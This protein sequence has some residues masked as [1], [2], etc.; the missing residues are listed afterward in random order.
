MLF[1]ALLSLSAQAK[2]VSDFINEHPELARSPS[3][4][5]AIQQSA[6]GLAGLEAV[7]N[8][9]TEK[10]L[11]DDAQ[12]LLSENGYEHAQAGLRELATSVCGDGDLAD[13]YGLRKKDCEVVVKVD[14]EIN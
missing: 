11:G 6:I 1:L 8:G 3:I 12:K 10:T 4:K 5:A 2:T 13:I 9:S 7:S 14:S